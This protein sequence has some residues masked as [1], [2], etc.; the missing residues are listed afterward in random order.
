M[1]A[2][3]DQQAVE[4]L[5][6]NG[7]PKPVR[8]PVRLRGAKRRA[9]DRGSP[10]EKP[11][12]VRPRAEVSRRSEVVPQRYLHAPWPAQHRAVLAERCGV[13]GG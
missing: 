2:V 12:A 5:R 11:P 9:N 6:A 7:A 13:L 4:T 1:L 10:K 3:R 8:Y